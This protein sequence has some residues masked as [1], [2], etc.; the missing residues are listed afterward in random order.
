MPRAWLLKRLLRLAGLAAVPTSAAVALVRD[1]TRIAAL[2][3]GTWPPWVSNVANVVQISSPAIAL[4][5][6]WLTRTARARSTEPGTGLAASLLGLL[7][8][9]L[10]AGDRERFRG[11]GAGEHGGLAMAWARR[12]AAVGGGCRAGVGGDPA[13]GAAAAGVTMSATWCR[14][15]ASDRYFE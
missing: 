4:L 13:V 1:W 2:M 8:L 3:N 10:P 9:L 7:A 6:V 5:A 14:A 11:R 15:A 12:G